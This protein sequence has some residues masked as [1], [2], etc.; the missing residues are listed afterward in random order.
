MLTIDYLFF[1]WNQRVDVA[2]DDVEYLELLW[3][4]DR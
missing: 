3:R 4:S 2:D 1:A